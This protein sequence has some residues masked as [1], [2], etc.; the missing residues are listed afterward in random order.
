MEGTNILHIPAGGKTVFSE[1]RSREF[2]QVILKLAPIY[3]FVAFFW[4]L[5]DQTASSW[6]LQ[7]KQ[8]NRE[9]LGI[10]WL[11][12]QI[13]AVNP[14]L[15]MVFIPLFSYGIYPVLNRV[16]PLSPLRKISIGFFVTVLAFLISAQIEQQIV[17][18]TRPNIVWQLLAFM[19]ITAAEVMV[20]ITCL[21]FSYTQAPLRFKSF[22]MALFLLSVSLGNG[23][24]SLVNTFIQR[25]DGTLIL[26]G[27]QY[28]WFFALI[29][30]VVSMLFIFVAKAYQ[31]ESHLHGRE[32]TRQN[33]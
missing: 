17:A 14:I 8:M 1:L 20:S 31:E 33:T 26:E 27:P 11:P 23:F 22:I 24:T 28:Y 4:S 7:A 5:Y 10:V 13:Q 19:V 25:A 9:W 29:M 18:G 6:V 12:S 2:W 15:I 30:F 21:E 32:P 16:F 3:I